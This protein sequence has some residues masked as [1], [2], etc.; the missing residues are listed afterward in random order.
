MDWSPTAT[1]GKPV[2]ELNERLNY[3]LFEPEV[4]GE[5]AKKKTAP[6]RAPLIW[7]DRFQKAIEYCAPRIQTLASY[8]PVSVP[9]PLAV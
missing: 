2:T 6:V 1:A 7:S 5:N 4:K 3:M 9:R 8:S